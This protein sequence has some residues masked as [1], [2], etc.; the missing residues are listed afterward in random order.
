MDDD[1]L[2]VDVSGTIEQKLGRA[3][4]L[5]LRYEPWYGHAA[6]CIRWVSRDDVR[7]MG[8]RLMAE[9]AFECAYSNKF[10]EQLTPVE[11]A[12]VIQH[13]IEHVVRGHCGRR[14]SNSAE[15]WNIAADMIVNGFRSKPN[16]G[17]KIKSAVAV[18]PFADR[19]CW[20]PEG[21]TEIRTVEACFK[22]LKC[23][24]SK[25]SGATTLD[26][27]SGWGEED[28]SLSDAIRGL[29]STATA[30]AGGKYPGHQESSQ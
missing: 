28:E 30:N 10:V 19:I 3:R 16:I 8:V 14:G 5:L 2:E 20:M 29:V 17:L 15:L 11:L 6:A 9:G 24:S 12:S 4:C 25:C 18:L 13:E 1:H 21:W 23:N 26:D 7:T 27:H 22:K